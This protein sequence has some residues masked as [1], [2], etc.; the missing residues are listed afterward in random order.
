MTTPMTTVS[1]AVQNEVGVG[2]RQGEGQDAEDRHPDHRLAPDPVA[3]R[4]A[5][6]GA[7]G[8]GGEEDEEQQLRV[9]HRDPELLD[10]EE[11][12]EA[13]QARE[14]EVLRED[15]QP[16]DADRRPS[17]A[18][19][20]AASPRRRRARGCRRCARCCA[21]AQVPT[22][23][24]S[25]IA[26]SASTENQAMLDWPNGS[27]TQAASSGPRAEPVLPPTWNSDWAKP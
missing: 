25:T 7:G 18:A 11:G 19:A 21:C 12:V 13:R 6:E 15:Q 2:Q 23:Q 9:A 5:D 20:A 27:T 26:T 17:P 16:E 24:S 4:A 3:D 1:T 8:D 22:F 14:V 10:Q